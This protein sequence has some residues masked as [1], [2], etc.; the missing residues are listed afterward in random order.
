MEKYMGKYLNTESLVRILRW[1]HQVEASA[2]KGWLQ[3][4]VEI[5]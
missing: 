4:S 1:K 5:R 2:G 3:I